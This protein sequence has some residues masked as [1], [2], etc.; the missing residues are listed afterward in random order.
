[1]H[2]LASEPKPLML[3]SLQSVL[4]TALDAVI[5]MNPDGTVAAWNRTAETTFG[6]SEVEAVG[7]S[8]VD[9]IIPL[10]HREAHCR[11]LERFNATGE[12]RVLNRRIEISAIDR[13]GR[14]F[15][16]ELSIT[17]AP[18][19]D[20]RVF[21]GF[22]R[23][24]TTRRQAEARLQRQA[25]E[26][27]LLFDVTR[28]A[29]DTNSFEDALRTSLQAIC[30]LTGWPVGHALLLKRGTVSELVST[31]VWHEAGQGEASGI[32]A[33]TE[34][35]QFRSGIGL[36]GR[37]LDSGEPAWISDLDQDPNFLRRGHGFGAAFAFPIKSE[38]RVIAVLE[39]FSRVK[40]EIDPDLMLTVRTLGEQV[41]RVL[42]RKQTEDHQR[43][44]LNELNH[45]VKNTLAIVQS[46]ANQTFGGGDPSARL[47]FESRLAALAAA[48][49]VLTAEKWESASLDDVIRETGVGCG[50]EESRL[51]FGGPPVRLSPKA[52]VS[53]SMALHELCTNA[54][55]YGALSADGGNVSISWEVIG[56]GGE[57]RLRLIWQER[58]GP[59]VEPPSQRGFG[60]R[61]IERAL[62]SE[63]GGTVQL[64]FPRDGVRCVINAPLTSDD[65]TSA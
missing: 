58:G 52:A 31:G 19:G 12:E 21:V 13:D 44:L 41:G 49:D 23:D 9:L 28:L 8:M 17:T 2:V 53:L 40:T 30:N 11:G 25:R 54:F 63:L 3:R 16:I 64:E 45:R 1:M 20:D 6:W 61:M 4:E 51:R 18:S 29:A 59:P 5:V 33:V 48:H 26:A 34:G 7:N 57:S 50:A 32:R 56:E 55:K 47:V 22:L 10:E 14:E 42:E 37:V 43:L 15:P 36:P 65:A 38:G 24:I 46:I 39:F 27:Q 60:S 35:V 62:A